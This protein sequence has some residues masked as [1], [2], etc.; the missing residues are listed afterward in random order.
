MSKCLHL[1]ELEMETRQNIYVTI[2]ILWKNP[3]LFYFI[4]HL[5]LLQQN[6]HMQ[7]GICQLLISQT[8]QQKVFT[9][10]FKYIMHKSSRSI[11]KFSPQIYQLVHFFHLCKAPPPPCGLYKCPFFACRKPAST[12]K[13]S[14]KY[15]T[16]CSKSLSDRCQTKMW[17]VVRDPS[18][19]QVT[20][21]VMRWVTATERKG[22][23][24][25]LREPGTIQSL[26]LHPALSRSWVL[27]LKFPEWL[28]LQS[29]IRVASSDWR[30]KTAIE[31]F[32]DVLF[33]CT[34]RLLEF[35][36]T[37]KR[38]CAFPEGGSHYAGCSR[39]A[40][41]RKDSLV[42]KLILC[43]LLEQ[44]GSFSALRASRGKWCYR[45]AF[46]CFHKQTSGCREHP[47]DEEVI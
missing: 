14:C 13:G 4:V 34:K 15:G 29:W 31:G 24:F 17:T 28:C 30:N 37:K 5:H 43:F 21:T 40:R 44:F 25:H 10:R 47:V 2:N 38:V 33:V 46:W 16:S 45:E 18:P 8:L 20:I 42:I 27:L 1:Y 26:R 32:S 7:M 9:H 12:C 3:S 11:Y 36:L 35:T 22:F 23:S 19:D 6:E 39:K 41:G